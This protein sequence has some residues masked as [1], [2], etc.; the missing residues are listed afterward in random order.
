MRKYHYISDVEIGRV[1]I[2]QRPNGPFAEM[3]GRDYLGDIILVANRTLDRHE[4][5]LFQLHE[6]E[7]YNW[8][9]CLA[10]YP[11]V[12]RFYFESEPKELDRGSFF[13]SVYRYARK[14]GKEFLNLGIYPFGEYFAGCKMHTRDTIMTNRKTTDPWLNGGH[15][16]DFRDDPQWDAQYRAFC[17]INNFRK[18]L[19]PGE[20]PWRGRYQK[21]RTEGD[22]EEQ[23]VDNV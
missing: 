21:R 13:H 6:I 5:V 15:W 17:R 9:G 1:Y 19:K 16:A 3:P 11:R 8:R 14:L 10:R 23:A 4:R 2:F 20:H 7:R 22:D 12:W 18:E